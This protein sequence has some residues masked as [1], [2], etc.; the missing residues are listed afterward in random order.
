M[1]RKPKTPCRAK[2]CTTPITTPG[3]CAEH[4]HLQVRQPSAPTPGT[5]YGHE[6]RKIRDAYK[7][8][9]PYCERCDGK[10]TEQV[11]HKLAQRDGGTHDWANLEALCRY[12]HDVETAKERAE[13]EKNQ[14]LSSR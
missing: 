3:Y 4:Q 14:R 12:H 5:D 11:H 1:P 9:H 7:A 10:P 13:R 8:A 2:G 6:W